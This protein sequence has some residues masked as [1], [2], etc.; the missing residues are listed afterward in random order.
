M[1]TRPTLLLI[2]SIIFVS[3]QVFAGEGVFYSVLDFE[4]DSLGEKPDVADAGYTPGSNSSINGVVVIDGASDPVA[5]P[6]SGKSLYAYDLGTASGNSTHFRYPFN[7]E[8]DVSELRVDFDFQRGYALEAPEGDTAMHFAVGR[9]SAGALNN[10]DYRPFR[11]SL[12]NDGTLSIDHL[13]GTATLGN[14]D[15]N[16]ANHITL[17]VNSH[18][19]GAVNYDLEDLGSGVIQPNT[20]HVFLENVK[21]GEFDFFI[22]PDPANA[23]QIVFDQENNDLGQVA[24]FQDTNSEGGIVF[25][26]IIIRSVNTEIEEILAPSN[27]L[28]E[29]VDTVS[30]TIAWTDNSDNE[31]AFIVERSLDESGPFEVVE[32]T[33]E[34]VTSYTDENLNS[35]TTY[36]Y[37]VTAFNGFYS[38][39]SDVLEVT[40]LEQI[41][42][43]IVDTSS[44]GAALANTTVDLGV[45]VIGREPISYQWYEGESGDE[46]NPIVSGTSANI[47]VSVLENNVV[48]WVRVSNSEASV[49]SESFEIAVNEPSVIIVFREADL[50]DVFEAAVPGDE[51]VIANGTYEDYGMNINASGTENARITVRAETPGGVILKGKSFIRFGGNYITASGFH[52]YNGDDYD[53]E[54][55]SSVVQ[56]RANNGNVHAHHCRLTDCAIIDMNSW[57]Q[58]VDDDDDDGDSEEFIFHSSK[59]IQLYGTNHRVDH[60]H[61]SDKKVRG[62]LL[63]TE[64][65]PQGGENGTPYGEYN[66]KIDNNYFGSIPV[67]FASNEFETL[68]LGTSDYSSFNGNMV[69]EDNYFYRCDG[70]IEVI[71]N[72]SSNNTYRNNSFIECQGSLVVR[73]G[74]GCTLEGN[75]ILG[76]G[77]SQTGGIR[78]N[79][80][81]HT[82]VNNYISGVRGTGLRA[83]LVLRAA[84]GVE[85]EDEDGGYDQ[86]RNALI[87]FNTWYDVTQSWNLGELGSKDNSFEPTSSTLANNII[88][89]SR[90]TLVTIGNEP[91]AMTYEGNIVHGSSLGI[92]ET[93][94]E[95]IDPLLEEG[96]F[97]VFR[98]SAQSPI[99]GASVGEYAS[100]AFD[101]DGEVRPATSADVGADQRSDLGR[102]VAP[103]DPFSVGPTWMNPSAI[104]IV[105]IIKIDDGTLQ[106]RFMQEGTLDASGFILEK[107]LDLNASNW[108]QEEAETVGP[109][110]SGIFTITIVPDGSTSF[111]RINIAQ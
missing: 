9:G 90:G 46:S 107:S 3:H 56:F 89:S 2:V 64:L 73:H 98:P 87:A 37:R 13:G 68:R 1:I 44:P 103:M 42:P 82:V 32:S 43:L 61:F 36:Y 65:I 22:T 39:S 12:F 18:D 71:S 23:P 53:R 95:E 5:N 27:L 34:S 96:N 91:T 8:A 45:A 58:D 109:D 78:L 25:D 110:E 59:W 77:I 15:T 41:D 54:V 79:G 94:F 100:V 49:D 105:N 17:L 70:E 62:A 69:V 74:D 57:E 35:V 85:G 92:S 111:W 20:I 81:G 60:C 52:F 104:E 28:I 80:E 75:V 30:A 63:I 26:N 83:G 106:V 84:G 14:Y 33:G 88:V 102:L 21:L 66:H 50:N 29:S 51:I 38:D 72:K 6:L 4:G 86:V 48:Y 11:L 31:N 10:S 101:I 7:G 97:G 76:G 40:T 93:G 108:G 19:S 16:N 24:I 47:S 67:G 55:G 99:L